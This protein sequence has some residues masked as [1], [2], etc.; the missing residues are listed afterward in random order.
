MLEGCVLVYK[1]KS[2]NRICGQTIGA[3]G[4]GDYAHFVEG[5]PEDA[6]EWAREYIQNLYNHGWKLDNVMIVR[7][8]SVGFIGNYFRWEKI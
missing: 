6:E 5:N 4:S 3:D 1:I 7:T 8:D 2:G